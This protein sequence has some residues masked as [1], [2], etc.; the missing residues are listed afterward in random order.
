MKIDN[1][2]IFEQIGN[3]FYAIAADQHVN[4]L[5]VGELKLLI[6]NDWLPGQA[7]AVEGSTSEEAHCI[8]MTMDSLQGTKATAEDAFREFE[9]FFKA[10]PEVFTPELKQRISRT[11][12]DI[13]Q[14]F[15]EDKKVRNK[16]FDEVQRLLQ[17]RESIA[18]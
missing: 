15:R 13:V 3:V 1:R 14:I 9:K 16:H 10:H 2:D 17:S 6:A 5:E 8:L 4:P 11:G 7:N 12:R 18:L